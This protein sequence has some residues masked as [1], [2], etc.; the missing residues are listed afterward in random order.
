[1]ESVELGEK[2]RKM[3]FRLVTSVGKRKILSPHEREATFYTTCHPAGE[4][5][6]YVKARELRL[7]R[8]NSSKQ[9]FV[10]NKTSG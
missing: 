3:F 2:L 7:L 5:K 1:M 6:G 4:K 10:Q 9:I 8:I